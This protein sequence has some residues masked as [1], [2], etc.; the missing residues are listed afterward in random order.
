MVVRVI[1]LGKG[2]KSYNVWPWTMTLTLNQPWSNI[3]TAHWHIILDISAVFFVHPTRVSKDIEWTQ[4][5]VWPKTITLTLKWPWSNKHSA[6]C[7]RYFTL[8]NDISKC[9]L[10]FT[11][12][13][14][15]GNTVIRCLTLNYDLDLKQTLIK[16]MH[17]TLTDHIWQLCRVTCKS[18][19]GYTW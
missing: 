5:C 14:A 10:P 7:R 9:H 15:A 8:C 2:P 1:E 3:R 4:L 19:K 17:C 16:N 18:H 12:Y 11:G 13:R 6:H